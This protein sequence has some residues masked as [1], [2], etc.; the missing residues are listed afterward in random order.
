[1]ASLTRE[2]YDLAGEEF[3]INSPK[4]LGVILFEK[5]QLPV[6]KKTKTGYSTAV[7]VLEDLAALS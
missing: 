2:I 1:M 4:Q 5:L 3:N 7:D 6:G